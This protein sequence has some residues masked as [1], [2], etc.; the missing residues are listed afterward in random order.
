M[1][2]R[3]FALGRQRTMQQDA[4]FGIQQLVDIALR[5]LSTGVNDA[6]TAHECVVHLGG[7]LHEVLHRDLPPTMRVGEQQRWVLRPHE[8]DHDDFV[9]LAL[10]QIRVNTAPMPHLSAALIAMVGQ[11]IAELEDA[12]LDDRTPSLR[13]QIE[14]C[15]AGVTAEEPLPEDRD[16]VLAAAADAGVPVAR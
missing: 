3:A 1:V 14:L 16:A 13:R 7:V 15:V 11:L 9:A 8:R 12:G 4:A 6:T 5:A 2:R 10:D